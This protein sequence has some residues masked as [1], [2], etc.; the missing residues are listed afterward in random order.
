[1]V[2]SDQSKKWSGLLT[3]HVCSGAGT[4]MQNLLLLA[5]SART[6]PDSEVPQPMSTELFSAHWI[7]IHEINCMSIKKKK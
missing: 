2:S 5:A 7:K 4:A 3:S 6:P 1:M